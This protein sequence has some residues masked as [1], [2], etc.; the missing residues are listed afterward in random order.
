MVCIRMQSI[1]GR[2]SDDLEL[3]AALCARLCHDIASPLGTLSGTLELAGEDAAEAAEAL[4]IA[5]EAA[6]ALVARLKLLRAA[7]AGDCGPLRRAQLED[8]ATGLPARVRADLTGLADAT[9][10]GAGARLMLN[11]LL[12]GAE[13]L[14]AGGEVA[15]A[16]EL[17][18]CMALTITGAAI[19]LHAELAAA[20]I[21]SPAAPMHPRTVQLMLTARLAEAAGLRLTLPEGAHGRTASLVLL[22]AR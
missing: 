4:S 19:A 13:L 14:P 16:G 3:A 18:G 15:L 20:L 2:R 7:W 11:L 21:G 5:G 9:F 12:L 6:D 10:D 22:A 17:P 1:I 8:L